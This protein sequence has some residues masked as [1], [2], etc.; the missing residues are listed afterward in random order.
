L[1]KG[2]RTLLYYL[3]YLAFEISEPVLTYF[4]VPSLDT[5]FSLTKMY[6]IGAIAEDL[7]LDM[8]TLRVILLKKYSGVVEQGFPSTLHFL[9]RS[10]YFLSIVAHL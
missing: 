8:A 10:R 1:N 2:A 7:N 4:L 5:A 6:N 3:E 9:E